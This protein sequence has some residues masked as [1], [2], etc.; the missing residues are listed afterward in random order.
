MVSKGWPEAYY[1]F[2]ALKNFHSKIQIINNACN[3]DPLPAMRKP[4]HG[5]LT[6]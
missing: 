4:G 2:Q 3:D 5:W 1:I 6:S